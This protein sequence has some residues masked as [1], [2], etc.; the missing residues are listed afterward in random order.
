MT[1]RRL[2]G[3]GRR[4]SLR[5]HSRV[6]AVGRAGDLA[7]TES[8]NQTVERMPGSAV[9]SRLHG[10]IL[11]ALPVIAHLCV[12]PEYALFIIH[13]GFCGLTRRLCH[14]SCT[15][16]IDESYTRRVQA[17][18]STAVSGQPRTLGAATRRVSSGKKLQ[19][20]GQQ[21]LGRVAVTTDQRARPAEGNA[22][23]NQR[24]ERTGGS[25][26]AHLQVERQQRLPP[27]AHADRY[28]KTDVWFARAGAG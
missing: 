23:P 27:V 7:T 13:R 14:R 24:V 2:I 25:R 22:W 5:V 18:V 28:A 10:I 20:S 17:R 9:T 26:L 11:G 19:T 15:G 1:E 4:L 16:K 6:F 8:P 21:R 12:R 3:C